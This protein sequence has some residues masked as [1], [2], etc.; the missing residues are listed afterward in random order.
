M[1]APWTNTSGSSPV[2][3]VSVP[4]VAYPAARAAPPMEE[5]SMAEL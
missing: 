3:P 1:A 2:W 4:T 5:K